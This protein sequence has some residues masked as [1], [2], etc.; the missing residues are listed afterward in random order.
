M[1]NDSLFRGT[2]RVDSLGAKYVNYIKTDGTSLVDTL[3]SSFEL[4]FKTSGDSVEK[5]SLV[6]R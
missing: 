3:E 1:V 2:F 6:G 5:K 4:E